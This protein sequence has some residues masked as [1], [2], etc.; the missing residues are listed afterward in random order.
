[1]RRASFVR[2]LVAVVTIWVTSPVFAAITSTGLLD[3][4]TIR[5]LDESEK[6]GETITTYAT[7]LFWVL[8]TISMVWTFG[9][10][11]LRKADIGEFFAEFLRFTVTTGFFWWLLEN[12]PHM[13]VDVI[14]AMRRIGA[15][16]G[17]V[18]VG[19]TASLPVSIGFNVVQKAFAGLSW[20][21][22]IDNLGIVIISGAVVI[23][24]AVVAANV[25]IALV[26]AWV[27]AYAGVF[28]LGFGGAR[29]TSDMAI[30]YFKA[31]LGIGLELMTMTLLVGIATSVIDGFYANLDATSIYELLLIF[32]VCAVL[33]LLINKIPKRVA[34]L[35][36][37]GS[38]A[39][40]GVG[41]VAGAAAMGA[42]AVATA[43]AALAAGAANAAGGFQALSA[44]FKKAMAAESG[45]GTDTG[46][47]A[48]GG[49]TSGGDGASL[50]TAM[51]DS[52]GSSGGHSSGGGKG[53]SQ[54][55]GASSG[56]DAKG[57]ADK[58][59]GAPGGQ[60][61]GGK[62]AAVGAVAAKA[63]RVAAGTAT[64]LAQGSTDVVKA[65]GKEMKENAL[66]R[67]GKT[68]GGQIA[69]AIIR[70]I[71]DEESGDTSVTAGKNSL[72]AGKNTSVDAESEVAAFRD[73]DSKTP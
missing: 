46:G 30:G 57:A 20:T 8:A 43:G 72:S 48:A 68:T 42:A 17:D 35:A 33:A 62:L 26:E 32:C 55:G 66:K 3:D 50:A 59:G 11:A 12:G 27:L 65:K 4:T 64:N 9:T 16:A 24:M 45:G 38:S 71:P 5:F 49:G 1:M 28:I 39:G 34:A 15:D 54:S 2:C 41:T 37:G 73:R 70:P 23:A 56:T 29:W 25:L 7:W 61:S 47:A 51:G 58:H 22:P 31:V 13:A 19:L 6:W 14:N 18:P 10:M 60:K 36:G 53:G 69:A 67:I 63:G 21:H 40:V 44:A 52:S